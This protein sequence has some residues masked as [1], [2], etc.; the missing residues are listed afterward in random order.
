MKAKSV[1][2]EWSATWLQTALSIVAL[3]FTVLAGFGVITPEQSAEAQPIVTS[4]LGAVS[5]AIAGV[6]ALIGIFFKQDEPV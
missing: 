2:R 6:L 3:V 1:K 5:T 4:T